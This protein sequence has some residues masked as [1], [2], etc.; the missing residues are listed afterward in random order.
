MSV[1]PVLMYHSIAEDGQKMSVSKH[2]FHKQM[3]TMLKLGFKGVN[4]RDV[5]KDK[6]KK[7]FVVTFDDGYQNVFTN[8]YP[9]LKELNLK[10]TCFFVTNKIGKF[11]EWDENNNYYKKRNI[12]NEDQIL[13]W[14]ENGFEVGSHSLDHE[15]LTKIDPLKKKDQIAMSKLFLKEKYKIDVKS[16]SY[17]FGRF[18]DDCVNIARKYYEYS[19]TTKR[20]RYKTKIFET[21]K[22][23]RIPVNSDTT[24][25]KFLIK[26]LTIYEDIKFNP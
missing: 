11:N 3:K 18:D 23:P 19:V 14:N 26:T 16:F 25:F 7:K 15:N 24:L 20:S 4:L 5:L 1:I 12:M 17:P 22:I 2:N 21:S 9:I 13:E 10:A 8:A 6:S